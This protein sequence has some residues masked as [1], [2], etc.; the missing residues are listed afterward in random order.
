MSRY[1]EFD[2]SRIRA[3]PIA[4]RTS[5]VDAADFARPARPGATFA[6]FFDSLPQILAGASLREAVDAIA[7]A[8]RA[9]KP[10]IAAMGAHVIKCGLT[11][12]I[13]DLVG[14]GIITAVATNGAGAI[15]DSEIGLF[16][17]TS[18]DVA[19]GL[20]DGTF[21]MA[22][23]TATFLNDAAREAKTRED[24]LGETIGR[25]L[26][27]RGVGLESLFAACWQS[28]APVTVHVG[29]GTDIVHMHD[30]ADGASYGEASL[31]DFRILVNCLESLSGGG[32]L[33]NIGSA[34]V[35]PEVILKGFA[36]LRSAGIPL[37]EFTS[38]NLDFI[39]QYRSGQQI[40]IRTTQLG[41]HGIA[42]T[43]HHE[44]VIPLLAH[45]VLDA[46]SA[47]ES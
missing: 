44:L 34:V 36:V 12:V 15:H 13:T 26:S 31:R 32:V 3:Q 28:G 22:E 11:P 20:K 19:A 29:I 16:G 40:V 27:E 47:E 24:G 38:I 45:A 43:G 1:S 8:H 6:E 46:L 17:I 23:E 39:Q 35:L 4:R 7:R 30:S 18:E 42:I 25:L 2:L 9:G 41:A 10:V 21:G 33:M 37:E 5:K 14:R